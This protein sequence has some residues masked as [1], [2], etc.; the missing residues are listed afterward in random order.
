MNTDYFDALDVF[1]EFDKLKKNYPDKVVLS[2]GLKETDLTVTELDDISSRVYRYLKEQNIGKEDMVNI[3]LPRGCAVIACLFGVWKAGAAAVIL[4]DDYPKERVDFIRKDSNCIIVIDKSAWETILKTDPL[5]GHEPLD[6]KAAAF[7]VYTSGTTGNPKGILHE[8]GKIAVCYFTTHWK[9]EPIFQRNDVFPVFFPMNFVPV[10]MI[11]SIMLINGVKIL[12]VPDHIRKDPNKLKNCF[13]EQKVNNAYIPPSLFRSMKDY[14]PYLKSVY[15]CS[16]P[17]NGIW[18]DPD[19]IRIL[20][21]YASSETAATVTAALLDKPCEIAPIGTPTTNLQVFILDEEGKEASAGQAGEL[22]CEMPYTRGYINLPE[23]NERTFINGI[24]HT[25]DLARKGSDGNYYLI[26]R[27]KDTVSINGKRVEPAEVEAAIR[28]VT[29]IDRVAVCSFSG[30]NGSY[31]CAYHLGDT[32]IDINGLKK[33]LKEHIPYYMIPS[34]FIKLDRFPENANGKLDRRALPRPSAVDYLTDYISP[35]NDI[36]KAI[37]DSMQKILSI[38]RIGINDDFFRLGGDS[39]LLLKLIVDLNFKGLSVEDVI[40]GKTPKGIAEI[41]GKKEINGS[42][43]IDEEDRKCREIPCRI[44]RDQQ[45]IYNYQQISPQNCMYNIYS[46]MRVEDI[47]ANELSLALKKVMENH[48]A[49]MTVLEKDGD[50]NVLQRYA[51]ELMKE[52][53]VEEVSEEELMGM[54]DDLV[55]PFEMLGHPLFRCR[56]FSTP[57]ASYFFMD[58]HHIIYDGFS[59]TIISNDI[60]RSLAGKA[61]KK[62]YYYRYMSKRVE[63]EKSA[64]AKKYFESK[65][66]NTDWT[67]ILKHDFE[68]PDNPADMVELELNISKKEYDALKENMGLGKNILYI[69]AGLFALAYESSDSDVMVSWVYNG[70]N[71]REDMDIVGV[72]FH[73]LPVALHLRDDLLMADAVEDIREQIKKGVE[74]SKYPYLRYEYSRVMV[75]DSVCIMYQ[76]NIYDFNITSKYNT[77]LIE[78]EEKDRAAQNS[79]DIEVIDDKED[80]YLLMDYSARFYKK[81]TI[82]KYAYLVRKIAKMIAGY[83]DFGHM[84]V[85]E[86]LGKLEGG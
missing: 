84:T 63:E 68:L 26:G 33:M 58:F 43:D 17:A 13:L 36:E 65:Y 27:I 66:G 35:T 56:V 61:L 12:V 64:E 34:F 1:D 25:G 81:D 67:K 21:S 50:G 32:D 16:E 23:Q 14:G 4:E 30:E 52:I 3:F 9:G 70:R 71:T 55:K 78:I 72:L 47:D 73:D 54:K 80:G 83:R 40:L 29:G 20:N 76:E 8:Y 51:P 59:S 85:K 11:A 5:D 6:L 69:T 2:E 39:L 10:V 79:L 41:Y 57:E 46:L 45:E 31:L 77:R 44:T 18:R 49:L 42:G 74:F 48:P 28:K 22:C 82:E 19:D 24:Y 38:P 7:A 15:I 75:D 62:D 37:C 60:T 53:E 86:F